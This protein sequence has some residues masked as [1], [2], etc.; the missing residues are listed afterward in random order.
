MKPLYEDKDVST[1]L[2]VGGSGDYFDVA[3]RVLM[4][5]EYKLKDVTAAAKEI[6]E[7]EGYRREDMSDNTFGEMT[8]RVLL[9]SGFPKSGKESR[10]KTKGRTTILYGREPIEISGLEQLV[11]DSQTNCI[12]V[13]IEYFRN[14]ILDDRLTMSETADR[15]Y[16][17]IEKNGLDSISPYSGHPGNLALPRK[18]EFIGT[19][20]RYRS[21]KVK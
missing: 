3:D 13:M 11:D 12:S 10:L 5:D 18:Q 8:E 19:L 6:A 4:M 17:D 15:I 7:T 14:Q 16:N 1:I 21:L 9:K 2:I 20:N